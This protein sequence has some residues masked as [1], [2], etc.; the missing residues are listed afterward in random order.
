MITN[1]S[2]ILKFRHGLYEEICKLAFDDKLD[3][4]SL[5]KLIHKLIP[6]KKP[7]YRCC[8]YK[9][10][11]IVRQRIRLAMGKD[12]NESDLHGGNIVQVIEA[13]CDECPISSYSVSSTP[14]RKPSTR[15]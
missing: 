7:E 10:R 2:N 13:A 6:D 9:E 3:E 1:D 8:I 12:T 14:I 11:E 5:E 15:P 4:E